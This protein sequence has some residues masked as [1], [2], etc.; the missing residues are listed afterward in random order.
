M[1][2]G[3]Y[4]ISRNYNVYVEKLA[5]EAARNSGGMLKKEQEYLGVAQVEA[6]YVSDF[7]VPFGTSN[8]KFIIQVRGTDGDSQKLDDCPYFQLAVEGQ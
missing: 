1:K 4:S 2:D 3:N 7:V 6:F 8:L 5:N